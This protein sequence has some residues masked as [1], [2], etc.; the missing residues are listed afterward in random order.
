M[1]NRLMGVAA[2]LVVV[3]AVAACAEAPVAAEVARSPQQA[4]AEV[5]EAYRSA[6]ALTDEMR[7]EIRYRGTNQSTLRNFLAGPGADVRLLI[8]GFVFTAVGGKL[9]A[10]RSDRPDK[11]FETP[12]QD[13]LAQT[14]LELTG[15]IP[16]PVP[17][18]ALRSA[19]APKDY[20]P[21]LGMQIAANLT[22]ADVETVRHGD[23]ALEVVRL[24][25][26]GGAKV[27]LQVD[28]LTSFIERLEVR[29]GQA[30]VIATMRPRRLEALP[31]PIEFNPAQRRRVDSMQDVAM[32]S[33][34]DRAPD[35]TLPTLDGK[36]VTLSDLKG[37]LVVIDFWASWC[38]PC[39]MGLPKLQQFQD[40]AR[41][42]HLP[43]KVLPVNVGEKVPGEQANRQR[44]EKFW[45]SQ[46]FTMPTLLDFGGATSLS[47]DVNGIPHTVV[48]GP[49][50][51]IQKVEVGFRASFT[52]ELKQL[53]RSLAT[54]P[55]EP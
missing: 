18:L 38:G 2:G 9:F 44:V 15:G 41:T 17:Q 7:V 4:L 21:S 30:T 24:T 26:D 29:A 42:E 50:G 31:E 54:E 33:P 35:F 32:L 8:D 14:Y 47:F 51:I 20:L 37:S 49:D 52:D 45:K 40:W 55:S 46:G 43:V 13:S 16:L 19:Q 1:A 25:G 28:P 27:E 34:G 48:V 5:A 10:Y 23:R 11:Y 12:L 39:R 36:A 6:P 22:P 53:A 3:G